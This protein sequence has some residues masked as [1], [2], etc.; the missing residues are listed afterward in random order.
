MSANPLVDSRDVRFVIFEMLDLPKLTK[1]QRYAELDKDMVEDTLNLA[2]R[3][4]VDLFYKSNA[5][6]DKTGVKHNP[7]TGEVKVPDSFHKGFRAFVEAGFHTLLFPPEEGGM[8]MPST[9]FNSC[10]E[11]FNAGNTSLGLYCA[12]ITGTAHLLITYGSEE[13]KKTF[14]P[15]MLAGEWAGTMCLTE[16]MAGTDVGALKTKAVRQSDGTYR[17]S[18]QKIFISTGEHDLTTN[19]IHPVLARIEGDAPGTKGISIFVVPKVLVNRD[20]SLGQRNDLICSGVEHKMGL[21]ANA[22]STLNFGDNDK[23]I[24]YLLGQ[25]RQGMKIMFQLMN[26]A[27]IFTGLQAQ[28]V[29]SAAYMH[30]VTYARNRI[31]SAHITQ[32]LNPNAPKVAIIEHPDVKR[33]LLSMKSIVEG[34]RM[35]TYYLSYNVD[36][37][38]SSSSPDEVKECTGAV[39][40]LTPIVKA[41]IS[42]AA[43][44]V[45]ADAMQVYGGYGYCQDYPVEQYARDAK[46]FSVY[47]GTNGVQSLDLQMRKILMNPN[48]YNYSVLKKR[49]NETI[50]KAKGIV[51]EK[52]MSPVERGLQK[53]DEAIQMM[54]KQ[55][56]EMKL[57]ALVLNATP[58]QQSMFQ[59]LLAW[60]HLWSLT[61]SIPKMKAILGDAKGDERQKMI[62]ENSEA[63]Y[64]SG[65]VLSSQFYIGSEFPK[66]FG[67]MECILGN[68]T[69]A[70][71][72]APENFTGALKE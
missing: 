57:M 19:I 64:Y 47:E 2:E 16:P 71:K 25:E 36:T 21:K 18:G 59:L 3:I 56:Q 22:T 46:V 58:L 42:D 26:E 29:S 6:G 4:A 17:I 48:Q 28:S 60:L 34:M 15:K 37:A 62:S 66:Y 63:A 44:L 65:R 40:I 55:M 24:G 41:G 39:E 67:K 23:C 13:I 20:G 27:R 54:N 49:M 7:E 8:G 70:I 50:Q 43:W 31:Q 68:E 38:I 12:G 14:L 9:I 1:N 32:M 69:A 52:Y 30:A 10:H 53:L 5:D 72:V 11:Y 45:T 35:L 51:E 33:M 61:V